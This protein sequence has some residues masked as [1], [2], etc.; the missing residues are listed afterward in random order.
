MLKR[1]TLSAGFRQDTLPAVKH[2]AMFNDVE[3]VNRIMTETAYGSSNGN[4]QMQ[5]NLHAI[6][7]AGVNEAAGTY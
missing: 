6:K 7:V 1:F 3:R 2:E 5:V 4:N